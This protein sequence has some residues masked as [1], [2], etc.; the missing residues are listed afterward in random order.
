MRPPTRT[1][2]LAFLLLVVAAAC[3]KSK[4]GEE[5]EPREPIPVLVK[6]ENFLDMNVSVVANSV[7]RRLG[8]VSGNSSATFKVDPSMAF[9][10]SITIIAV[11]I[12]GRGTASSGA[13]NVGQG[14][15]IEFT[16]RPVLRQS[17]AVVR[18]PQQH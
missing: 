6:N 14:Q 2:R 3:F 8:T 18:E 9:G 11:P 5:P 1:A 13:M 12:G 15:M 10:Q 16:I 7:T 4:P 17:A